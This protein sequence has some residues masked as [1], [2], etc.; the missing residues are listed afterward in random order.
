MCFPFSPLVGQKKLETYYSN[1]QVDDDLEWQEEENLRRVSNGRISN[2]ETRSVEERISLKTQAKDTLAYSA[3]TIHNRS[4]YETSIFGITSAKSEIPG[5]DV[6]ATKITTSKENEFQKNIQNCKLYIGDVSPVQDKI[7]KNLPRKKDGETERKRKNGKHENQQLGD[8]IL[9]KDT[10]RKVDENNDKEND[11]LKK[12]TIISRENNQ[13]DVPK[14]AY[15]ITEV[16]SAVEAIDE[17]EIQ[18]PNKT[19]GSIF[20]S[21]R[22]L[23]NRFMKFSFDFYEMTTNNYDISNSS[24]YLQNLSK[25]LTRHK[26]SKE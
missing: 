15:S 2:A 13:I 14:K 23:I 16:T 3:F 9:F 21:G 4:A 10:L 17:N 20:S 1:L 24:N 7:S 5:I 18:D 19:S 12:I 8:E 6:E 25:R 22:R 26:P 11:C